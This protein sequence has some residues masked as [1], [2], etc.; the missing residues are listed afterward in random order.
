MALPEYRQQ[1]TV[2]NGPS[3]GL[4]PS[5]ATVGNVPLPGLPQLSDASSSAR[6]V[7]ALGGELAAIGAQL[8]QGRQ[9]TRA[10]QAT[11]TFLNARDALTQKYS[12]DPDYET[13]EA[14]FN[15][16]IRRVQQEQLGTINDPNIRARASLEMTRGIITASDT[17]RTAQLT[18]QKDINVAAL[19]T[20]ESNSTREVLSAAS[21]VDRAAA[22]DRYGGEVV[23]VMN[24]GWIDQRTAVKLKDEFLG[25]IDHS[26][27]LRDIQRDPQGTAG[28]LLD[29]A[30][31]PTLDPVKR[32]G[33]IVSAQQQAD[34]VT[35]AG[36]ASKA[37]FNPEQAQLEAGRVSAPDQVQKIF[38]K[39]IVPIESNGDNAAVSPKGALGASQILPGTARDVAKSLGLR[40]LAALDDEGLKA[41]LLSDPALNLRLG[42]A[43]FQ[44]L[45]Q[46]YNGNI[47]L[48]AAGYNAGP[49]K[50]DEWKAK[51]EEK[52]GAAFTPAQLASVIDYKETRDYV[53]KLYARFGASMDVGFSSPVA[54]Q[55][56]V[57]AVGSAIGEQQS[58]ESSVIRAMAST[59]TATDNVIA[60]LKA[61]YDVDPQREAAFRS[62]QT[63]A[64][65]TGDQEA[66][67]RLRDL[68]FAK[69]LH[70][71]IR[72][73]WRTDPAQLDAQ[74]NSA[75]AAVTAAGGNVS[76][77]QLNFIK[78]FE[79]VQK[80]Q[81]AQRDS[82]PVVL[83]GDNGGRYYRLS[84]LDA[85]GPAD[86]AFVASLRQRDAQALTANKI[87]GGSGSPF[88]KEEAQGFA[89]RYK[90]AAPPERA[91]LLGALSRGL[92]PLT[93]SAALEQ[94]TG[95]T[96][97]GDQPAVK[98]AAGVYGASPEIAQSIVEGIA[99]ANADPRY[100]PGKGANK[101][102]YVADKEQHLPAAAFNRA[103]R[104]DP[105]GPYAAL[106]GAIDARYA[107]LSAQANDVSGSPN[108]GRLKQAADDVTGGILF[109]NGAPLIAPVRGMSQRDFDATLL[110]IG[111]GDLAGAQTTSGK[112]INA[113]YLRGSAKLQVVGDGRY[114]LQVNR[115]DK[116]PQYAM[117]PQGAPFVLDLRNRTKAEGYRPPSAFSLGDLPVL[118]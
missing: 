98:I 113:G 107:F 19:V 13:A 18:R 11:E 105:Q 67:K 77:S 51:A 47:G 92:S 12:R 86:D 56:A 93:F 64:A 40:D 68:D 66:A 71:H 49:G 82:Q 7:G 6:A 57:N 81:A 54:A 20:F 76:Q 15:E 117:T 95:E 72:E 36:L 17:V 38:L 43:Y 79:E 84:P 31:Y 118:P 41:R 30:N 59:A 45:T 108:R 37:A 69:E 115:D 50:A 32:Q 63:S 104:T 89:Q 103:A 85:R 97:K 88:T 100:T 75:R 61:G 28:K 60:L 102:A 74:L 46:R 29:A 73:A 48:A 1:A 33:L 27:A 16:D 116:Q 87:Y 83:G 35:K 80:E 52:F 55:S 65:A 24:A 3:P 26:E 94:V 90:D 99:A 22:I 62:A 112:P 34:A 8:E 58:R 106:S 5:P 114:I 14:N 91:A 101:T 110:G 21:P 111:D 39:G 70:P 42:S 44:Q 25:K 9:H 23:R 96:A 78:A 109:H 2:G 4:S 10:S 53:G